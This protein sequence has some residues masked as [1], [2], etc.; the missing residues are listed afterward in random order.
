MGGVDIEVV[1][2]S[3]SAGIE[4][5][6]TIRRE[7]F[8][9][10]LGV[11]VDEEFDELDD[12]PGTVHVLAVDDGVGVGTARLLPDWNGGGAVR[13]TRV[14]VVAEARGRGVGRALMGA[15]ERIA[16]DE[17]SIGAPRRVRL[18]LSVMEPAVPFYRSLGYTVDDEW[19]L[20]VR[21]PHHRARKELLHEPE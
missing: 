2:F 8:V 14:A 4:R 21:I 19:H 11:T 3:D 10:E 18:D 13:V 1:H 7:V 15:V 5:A 6:R 20:E 16:W 9:D 12:R 17:H